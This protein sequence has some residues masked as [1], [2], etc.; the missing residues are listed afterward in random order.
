[1]ALF[2][3][4]T[5]GVG[6]LGLWLHQHPFDR[7]LFLAINGLGRHLEIS[8]SALSVLGLGA[9]VIVLAAPIG[10]RHPRVIAA[11]LLLVLT[12]GVLVQGLKLGLMVPRPAAVLEPGSLHVAG[13]AM[14]GRSMPSGHA[15]VFAAIASLALL[16]PWRARQPAWYRRATVV[17]LALLA[18]A[19]GLARCAVGAHWPSDV[20]VGA[21][22]GMGLSAALMGSPRGPWLVDQLAAWLHSRIGTRVMVV[23]LSALAGIIWVGERHHPQADGLQSAIAML[24]AA[25]AVAWW[26]REP[27]PAWARTVHAAASVARR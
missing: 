4:L 8:A 10:L 23:T 5:A 26:L 15:A 7:A 12:G 25:C 20:M 27:P 16:W 17:G 24:G 2:W 3:A 19:G 18:V 14:H 9:S 21:A 1:M 13:L 11:M 22:L 6:L